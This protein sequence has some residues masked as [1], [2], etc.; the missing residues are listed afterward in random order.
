MNHTHGGHRFLR[1]L[2]EDNVGHLP[3]REVSADFR[4]VIHDHDK[5]DRARQRRVQAAEVERTAALRANAY[6]RQEISH[7]R[8]RI[9]H[10]VRKHRLEVV[11]VTLLVNEYDPSAPLLSVTVPHNRAH[12]RTRHAK[13]FRRQLLKRRLRHDAT[14]AKDRTQLARSRNLVAR[15]VVSRDD[16]FPQTVHDLVEQRSHVISVD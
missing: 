9:L 14:Y 13:P 6:L 7:I 12:T 1:L 8:K 4:T 2:A 16:C 15:N 5:I 3:F 11:V 10:R